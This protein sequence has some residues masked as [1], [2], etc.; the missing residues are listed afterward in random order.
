MDDMKEVVWD[1][2][3]RLICPTCKILMKSPDPENF[4]NVGIGRCQ[5]GHDFKISKESAIEI[6]H[7]W[8]KLTQKDRG[9][10]RDFLKN[11]E[12][13]PEEKSGGGIILPPGA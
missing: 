4:L 6:N 5:Q 7:L 12:G 9:L 13:S 10:T 8:D 1:R 2:K 11:Q 3:G